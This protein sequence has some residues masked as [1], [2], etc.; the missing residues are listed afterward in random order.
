MSKELKEKAESQSDNLEKKL[1]EKRALMKERLLAMEQM[2][3]K[4]GMKQ[5]GQSLVKT[6][7]SPR[8][9]P[10]V[11][12]GGSPVSVDAATC[13]LLLQRWYSFWFPKRGGHVWSNSKFAANTSPQQFSDRSPFCVVC[14]RA[15]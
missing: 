9:L 8:P 3:D 2:L 5:P 6:K 7:S 13:S 14:S 15:R 12:G 1:A 10:K 4:A 11:T